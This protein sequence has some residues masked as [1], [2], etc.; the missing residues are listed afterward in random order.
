MY[1]SWKKSF[2]W[3]QIGINNPFITPIQI[4]RCLLWYGGWKHW[5][6]WIRWLDMILVIAGLSHFIGLRS[7][8]LTSFNYTPCILVQLI[9]DSTRMSC[10]WET[11]EIV[12]NPCSDCLRWCR[13][14]LEDILSSVAYAV[15]TLC[16]TFWRIAA[17][18][19][20]PRRKKWGVMITPS[21]MTI[22]RTITASGNLVCMMFG[23]SV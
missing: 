18:T 9:Q 22:T 2:I 21:L 11:M 14:L 23:M 19:L 10:F 15:T 8:W 4:Q 12:M 5:Y 20:K 7:C 13:V 3:K 6:V 1:S 17:L 16:N